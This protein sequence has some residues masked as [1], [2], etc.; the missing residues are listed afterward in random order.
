MKVLHRS[1]QV[2]FRDMG[3]RLAVEVGVQQLVAWGRVV[4]VVVGEGGGG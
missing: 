2:A 4:V 3:T 1:D